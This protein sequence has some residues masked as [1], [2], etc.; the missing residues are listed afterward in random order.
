MN[1]FKIN[2]S[3]LQNIKQIKFNV[4]LSLISF[5]IIVL[6]FLSV[7]I[8]TTKSI[9]LY[10]IVNDNVIKI[11]ISNELSDVVKNNNYVFVNN[12]KLKYKVD[13]FGDVEL[14]GEKIFQDVNLIIDEKIMNNEVV[15]IILRYNEKRLIKH[16]LDLFK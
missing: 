7:F 12:K 16:I 5:S 8:K 9:L 4:I 14:V 6:L 1:Y 2:Y 11:K 15:K 10:G 3:K 13:S